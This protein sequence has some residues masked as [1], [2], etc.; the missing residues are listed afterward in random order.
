MTS[1]VGDARKLGEAL[2]GAVVVGVCAFPLVAGCDCG[3]GTTDPDAFT[4]PRPDT[5]VEDPDAFS[6]SPDAFTMPGEDANIDVNAPPGFDSGPGMALDCV[7]NHVFGEDFWFLARDLDAAPPSFTSVAGRDGTLIGVYSTT[8]T[9]GTR[10]LEVFRYD[11]AGASPGGHDPVPLAGT[12]GGTLPSVAA[13]AGGYLVSFVV[14]TEIRVARYDASLAP[15]GSPTMAGSDTVT[16][17]PS[18]AHTGSGGYVVWAAGNRIRGRALDA[19]GAPTGAVADL[20][21]GTAPIQ[22]ATIQS[23]GGSELGVAWAD[24]MSRPSVARLTGGTLGTAEFVAGDQGIF[25]SID[26]GGQSMGTMAGLPLAGAAVYDLNDLGFRDVI[27]RVIADGAVPMFPS[28]TVGMGGDQAWSASVEPYLSG[29]AL[30]YRASVPGLDDTTLLRVGYLDREGCRLGSV[31]DR[32]V[33]GVIDSETGAV[34]QLGAQGDTLL[35]VWS[36]GHDGF[37]DYWA[38]TLT[39]TERS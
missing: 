29:F 28:A 11:L 20:F 36:D 31:T 30:A 10:R 5:N 13:T 12:D 2:R 21:T 4:T 27:F 39:C 32:F 26:M 23:L 9:A 15:M 33:I 38:S 14:G 19:S 7:H 24:G 34:P 37:Y 6:E 3:G 1:A 17:P 35:I 8:P 22:Q 16:V 18:I 25:T